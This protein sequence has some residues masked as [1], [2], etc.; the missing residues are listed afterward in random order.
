MRAFSFYSKPIVNLKIF[1]WYVI[2]MLQPSVRL[3]L[4]NYSTGFNAAFNNRQSDSSRRF[5]SVIHAHHSGG[6]SR[7]S[8]LPGPAS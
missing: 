4:V 7:I 1:I 2:K 8:R 5:I 6:N 3:N